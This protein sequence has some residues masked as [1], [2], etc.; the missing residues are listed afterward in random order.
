[1]HATVRNGRALRGR[2]VTPATVSAWVR[3][4]DPVLLLRIRAD[5][6]LPESVR[7]YLDSSGGQRVRTGYKC[8]NRTPWYVV[9]DVKTPDAFLSYM[10]GDAPLLVANRAKCAC[11]NSVHAVRLTDGVG[12]S[13]LQRA[14]T[15]CLTRLSCEIEGHPLGG[16]LLK[17]EPREASRILL[18][19]E[20]I[21]SRKVKNTI[22]DGIHTMRRW[23]HY[24]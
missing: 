10:C 15:G 16:G 1:M 24:G 5:D 21:E 3:R 14:W 9:P 20:P 12:I 2:A 19:R 4:D 22:A 7:A 18:S 6:K 17:I 13:E 23:R 11:T 8:R